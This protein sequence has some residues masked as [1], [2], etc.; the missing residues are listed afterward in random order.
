MAI[1]PTQRNITARLNYFRQ[2]SPNDTALFFIAG[3]GFTDSQGEFYF[4]PKDAAYKKDG[5]IDTSKAISQDKL[6]SMLDLP[7]KKII[8]LDLYN[9]EGTGGRENLHVDYNSLVRDLQQSGAVVIS[10]C[11]GIE[12]AQVL[13]KNKHGVFT[14]AVMQGLKGG[15]DSTKDGVIRMDE[16]KTYLNGVIPKLTS[17]MQHP[18]ASIPASFLFFNAARLR[19]PVG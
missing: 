1:L 18:I 2:L 16:L 15:A 3:R 9:A 6:F 11:S 17:S 7:C 14:Y 10:S 5:T 19:P 12:S 8:L 13:S 4:L